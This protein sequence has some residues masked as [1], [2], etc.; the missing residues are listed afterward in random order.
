M[1]LVVI[2]G[3]SGS[4]K[5]TALNQLEDLGYYCVDNLPAALLP[6]LT[7][8]LDAEQYASFRGVAVCID[9]RNSAP[10]LEQVPAVL[11]GLADRVDCQVL[12]LDADDAVLTKRF[13]ET[14][15]RHPLS[16]ENCSLPEA[17][18]RETDLL[19]NLLQR[20]DLTV[21]TSTLTLY[22]LR[23]IISNRLDLAG[24]G[25]ISLLVESFG[26]KRGVPSDADIVFDARLLPNPHWD[27]MMRALTGKDRLVE[28]FLGK[29][30]QT[31]QF[32]SDI[33]SWLE[34]WLP[35]YNDSQRSYLTVAIGC[36]GG[37]HRSV[38]VAESVFSALGATH[39]N[40]QIRHREL[41]SMV[42]G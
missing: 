36:T 4:G 42:T 22:D 7:R 34:R 13:S 2:S 3:R 37:Q 12:Y 23:S 19:D 18:A 1:D 26:F 11:A 30:P 35:H 33:V 29:H 8:Q 14:R 25:G 28:E 39:D 5:S 15:R 27:P 31:L 20:A 40:I 38:F 6:T 16:N 10:D 32:V 24:K 21:D 9:V 41:A 17:I